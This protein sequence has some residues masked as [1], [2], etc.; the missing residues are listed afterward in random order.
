[1]ARSRIDMSGQTY[2][3]WLVLSF[4]HTTKAQTFW[5]CQCECGK[6][7]TLDGSSLRRGQS[8]ACKSCSQTIHG[9]SLFVRKSPEYMTWQNMIRRCHKKSSRQYKNYGGRGIAVCDRWRTSFV[10]FLNDMG[11]KPSPLHSIERLNNDG[12]YEPGNCAWATRDVQSRNRTDNRIVLGKP[13]VDKLN[14]VGMYDST[15]YRR[16]RRGLSDAEALNPKGTR[17]CSKSK[18]S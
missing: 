10:N 5:L 3:K 17:K 16:K 6:Q 9:H 7:R 14:E 11:K 15:F 2:G 18:T 12:N 1:M 4:S 8:H 13:L